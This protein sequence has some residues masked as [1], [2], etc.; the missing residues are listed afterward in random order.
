ME[1][2]A[3]PA[4]VLVIALVFIFAFRKQISSFISGL[5]KL[6]LPGVK[7]STNQVSA[8]TIESNKTAEKLMKA[9]DNQLLLD[10]EKKITEAMELRNITEE[11]EKVKI[12]IR[13]LASSALTIQFEQIYNSIYGSQIL[14]LEDINSKYNGEEQ[15]ILRK[16][17]DLY[18]NR[19]IGVPANY[20]YENYLKYLSTYEL[21]TINNNMVQ[22]TQRGRDT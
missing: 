7:A 11:K 16:Y 4:V 13:Y 1:Y 3:W 18:L 9:F 17:Y 2:L 10:Q 14:L 21:I 6:D 15:E 8:N 12:L 20:T 5:H 22:I 19:L